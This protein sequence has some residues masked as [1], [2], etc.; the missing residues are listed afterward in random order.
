MQNSVE[1]VRDVG[2]V[3]N[4]GEPNPQEPRHHGRILVLEDGACAKAIANTIVGWM[5]MDVETATN[6]RTACILATLSL[7]VGKPYAAILIDIDMPNGSG[8]EAAKWLRH[9]IWQLPIIGI[10]DRLGDEDRKRCA[11]AG[12]D[13]LIEKPLTNEKLQAAF[14]EL[15]KEKSE[16]AAQAD[17]AEEKAA[18]DEPPSDLTALDESASIESNSAIL[19]GRILVAEDALCVQAII[20]SFLNKMNFNVDTADN[21]Q[22]ACK[23]AMQSLD[24]GNPYDV[25]LMDIQMPKM[26]GKQAA[27]W[28]R[29]NGWKGTI[30]A[31]SSHN[32]EKDRTAIKSA[33]CD[34]FISKPLTKKH[35][36]EVLVASATQVVGHHE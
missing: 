14:V 18:S 1:D 23:M 5:D 15:A 9:H 8:V 33:G 7:A 29:E 13:D 35:L 26:N 28:L 19:H 3:A 21:G 24:S 22:I 27:K 32:T 6:D 16:Q 25:I 10:G 34:G 31:V 2:T 11:A 4:T 36:Q 17:A 12:F 20:G 30:I